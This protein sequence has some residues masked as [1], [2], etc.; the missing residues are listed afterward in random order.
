MLNSSVPSS[1][2]LADQPPTSKPEG[3]LRLLSFGALSLTLSE[4]EE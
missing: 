1:E 4:K 2:L 3:L